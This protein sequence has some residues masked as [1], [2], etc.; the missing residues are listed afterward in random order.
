VKQYQTAVRKQTV[1]NAHRQLLA[2][3]SC[4]ASSNS[5]RKLSNVLCFGRGYVRAARRPHSQKKT[6]LAQ[7][8]Q[9]ATAAESVW[10]ALPDRGGHETLAAACAAGFKLSTFR[11]A[12]KLWHNVDAH[13]R[14]T[15]RAAHA[16][17]GVAYEA[18]GTTNGT[19]KRQFV[20]Y[21]ER[22]FE[23]HTGG[24]FERR[25]HRRHDRIQVQVLGQSY[26]C[27]V[28]LD[29]STKRVGRH[30]Q[31]QQLCVG[32][33]TGAFARDAGDL[34]RDPITSNAIRIRRAR[35]YRRDGKRHMVQAG[36]WRTAKTFFAPCQN[37][38]T[39]AARARDLVSLRRSRVT[40]HDNQ[41]TK[42]IIGVERVFLIHI[43]PVLA[44]IAAYTDLAVQWAVLNAEYFTGTGD[45]EFTGM[46]D[47]WVDATSICE[48]SITAAT[49]VFRERYAPNGLPILDDKLMPSAVRYRSQRPRI[50]WL[51]WGSETRKFY[52]IV[53]PLIGVQY[54]LMQEPLRFRLPN[55]RKI[56]LTFR[57][58]TIKGD[59]HCQ[60]GLLGINMAGSVCT[61][62]GPWRLG[63]GEW[64]QWVT[65]IQAKLQETGRGTVHMDC[66]LDIGKILSSRHALA[67]DESYGKI[68]LADLHSPAGLLAGD[69]DT[70][71]AARNLEVGIIIG[72]PEHVLMAIIKDTYFQFA[73]W[74]GENEKATL[75]SNVSRLVREVAGWR[76]LSGGREL[77]TFLMRFEDVIL[78]AIEASD[79]PAG[80]AARIIFS[81]LRQIYLV[82]G[83]TRA[84]VHADESR[85]RAKL[86]GPCFSFC[87]LTRH[88]QDIGYFSSK[89][90]SLY[91]V[92]LNVLLPYSFGTG[93][94][95]M[96]PREASEQVRK[97]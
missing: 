23:A 92:W 38:I 50:S 4:R 36:S 66:L 17:L 25:Q 51:A 88:M 16:E 40:A 48:H 86:I 70:S 59:H 34:A 3:H 8:G 56:V 62:W 21:Y 29:T 28:L 81:A 10:A 71:L 90:S 95:Q 53:A 73:S 96:V 19:L 93:P 43:T 97:T 94:L 67:D 64:R 87:M 2:R 47:S 1:G 41:H 57:A 37:L 65:H 35:T 75:T 74:L 49:V 30:R 15:A 68:V 6:F 55:G 79:T 83:L 45:I 42:A 20:Q 24:A 77:K 58:G 91:T 31:I 22:C 46:M 14:A 33:V 39:A 76:E 89:S 80:Q 27:P 52:E 7:A 63:Y 85:I 60:Q 12:A 5:L 13:Y 69:F 11:P 18:S 44:R 84:Q 26:D 9:V 82:I 54:S 72:P 32:E 61:P 78:P